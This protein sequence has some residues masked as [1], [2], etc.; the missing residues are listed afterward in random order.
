MTTIA[1]VPSKPKTPQMDPDAFDEVRVEW[2]VVTER[3]LM[4]PLITP[5]PDE[6]TARFNSVIE[7]GHLVRRTVY[8]TGWDGVP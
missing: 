6:G 1:R 7:G 3:D 4:P 5:M 2:A 8:V